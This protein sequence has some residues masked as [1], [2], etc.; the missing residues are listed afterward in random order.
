MSEQR[1]I[2]Y[3]VYW[4]EGEYH[5]GDE[6]ELEKWGVEDRH[7]VYSTEDAPSKNPYGEPPVRIPKVI[8]HKNMGPIRDAIALED[9]FQPGPGHKIKPRGWYR[10]PV[11]LEF[12]M[13]EI[14]EE[15]LKSIALIGRSEHWTEGLTG[16]EG[17]RAQGLEGKV[18]VI[19]DLF[20]ALINM[21]LLLPHRGRILTKHPSL[22]AL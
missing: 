9:E 11:V 12:P 1:G 8:T 21:D 16:K 3:Y 15:A 4:D 14:A 13:G 5:V 19:K 7:V 18:L 2:P 20:G 6:R 22:E 17:F 10:R